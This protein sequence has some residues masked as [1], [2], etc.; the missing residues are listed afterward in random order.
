MNR[1]LHDKNNLKEIIDLMSD[2]LILFSEDG[3]CIDADTHTDL[4]FLQEDNL[5]GKNIIYL[6]PSYTYHK[7][8][9]DIQN[10][11]S[12]GIIIT[13]KYRL[14]LKDNIYFVDCK[15]APYK[16]MVLFKVVDITERENIGIKLAQA[17]DE[18]KE[19]QKIAQIGKWKLDCGKN[20]ITYYGFLNDSG[21]S[22]SLTLSYNLLFELIIPEDRENVNLWL[23]Y[24][25]GRIDHNSLSFRIKIDKHIYI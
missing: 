4:W 5:I 18:M 23:H 6:L 13:R 12:K 3:T 9:I 17:N 25:K 7:A 14:P 24:N 16:G 20:I 15:L 1:F 10:V 2:T 21:E 8:I 22:N 19:I 11:I